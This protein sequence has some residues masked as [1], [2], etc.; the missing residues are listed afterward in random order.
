MRGYNK[1]S[2]L[3]DHVR[4]A[5]PVT[6]GGW[7]AWEF[8]ARFSSVDLTDG[9]IEGGDMQILSLGANWWLTQAASANVNF[10]NINLDRFGIQGNVKGITARIL[11]MLQ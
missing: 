7:G 4:V 1:R 11:V 10:R 3:F 2:G 8:A 9:G 6:Q 5:K